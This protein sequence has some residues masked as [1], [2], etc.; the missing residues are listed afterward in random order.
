[1]SLLM[2]QPSKTPGRRPGREAA[3]GQPVTD[4]SQAVLMVEGGPRAQA[5]VPG[6]ILVGRSGVR[7]VERAVAPPRPIP[8][9]V[10]PGGRRQRVLRG[11]PRG[12]R[13]H[14]AYPRPADPPSRVETP[15]DE[16]VRRLFRSLGPAD[17][18]RL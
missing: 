6:V 12:R 18:E 7:V 17:W 8:N 5:Q 10:V 13:G 14:R 1:M 16:F 11:R 3:G 2:G 15:T 4:W 9:R